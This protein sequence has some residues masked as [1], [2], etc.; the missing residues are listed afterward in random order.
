MNRATE[1]PPLLPAL[2]QY[3]GF[4]SFRPLQEEIILDALR[5]RDVF[6]LLPTGGGKSLC[7]QLPALV[8]QGLVVVVSPLISLMKDQVDALTASGVPAT[9]LNSS[10]AAGESRSR[11]RGLHQGEFRL[12]YAAPERLMLSGFLEDLQRWN[13]NLIAVDEAHCISE[14]GHDFRPE[15]R[16]LAELRDRLPGVPIMALTATAT[17]R[18]R[19]DIVERLRLADPGRY[20]A[21][22]NRPN[23]TYRVIP[24]A[25]PYRQLHEYVSA[26][27]RDCGIVYCQSRKS[28]ESLASR[29][30]EDGIPARA[31]HAGLTP[32]E[33]SENQELFLRDEV[34]VVCA[35]IAFGMG[36]NKPNVRY[37]IHYDLPKNIEGYYQET[38]RA[39]RDGLPSDCLLLFSAGDVVKQTAF[40]DEKP[41]LDE[42][43]VAREQ[44]QQMVHYA[45]SAACRRVALLGYFGEEWPD[46]KCNG[47]DN[48]LSPRETFDGTLAAQKFLSCVYRVRE[49]NGFGFGLNQIVEILTG[50]DTENIRKWGH[51]KLSTYGIGSEMKRA[52]W[53]AIGREL[54][55]LGFLRQTTEKFSVI[56]LAD[57]GRAAL[58]DRR[59]IELTKPAAVPEPKAKRAGEIACDEALFERLRGLRRK[60]AD[61]RDVP[62]YIIFSDVTLREMAREY[63]ADPAALGRISG[64]GRQK[65]E[66]F[67]GAF[68]AEIA[69]YLR[70][71]PRQIFA[72][73]FEA[74]APPPGR[75]ALNDTTRET[76][77]QLRSGRS[78]EEIAKAR[79]FATS[80]IFGHLADALAAGETL[81]INA[82]VSLEEQ[83][84][85]ERAFEKVGL[86]SLG[87]VKE[88]LG[89]RI[90]YGQLRIFR[91]VRGG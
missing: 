23:L 63:P 11:L 74:P 69:D 25:Q 4:D 37:V 88:L 55:R 47:C 70:N 42:Q 19:Q 52:E 32:R 77:R 91:A 13:V 50:A 78:V 1:T 76:L 24:K 49:R 9:F 57:E 84:L 21:S 43:R 60:L 79:G 17:G 46:G 81:D 75:A 90:S 36:I 2:R 10:L 56:E 35:T 64:V 12:L 27:P 65:R 44:L 80:T 33:R 72:D 18:V 59:K 71:N 15:Y 66:Q 34:R 22:F 38:G 30:S 29:L 61:E 58:R 86:G 54:V 39:G 83:K 53:Q 87:T 62:A 48:C 82:I 26:R 68:V 40:I 7:F 16:Q 67:G 31:Y 28:A 45:E 51:D 73:S 3:F 8:R 5:G 89:D 41:N 20:V 6:A 85:I 14:W